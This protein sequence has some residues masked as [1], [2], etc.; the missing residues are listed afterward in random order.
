MEAERRRN[1]LRPPP[2]AKVSPN[3]EIVFN[4]SGFLADAART[5]QPFRMMS[6]RQPLDPKQDGENIVRDP[7]TQRVMGLKLISVDF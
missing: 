1:M 7:V 4:Y 3:G 2:R 6:L 5:N